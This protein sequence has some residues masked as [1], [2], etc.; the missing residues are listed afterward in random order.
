LGKTKVIYYNIFF[1]LI[2][3]CSSG[4]LNPNSSIQD[5]EGNTL[6]R[7]SDMPFVKK[8]KLNIEDRLI[9]ENI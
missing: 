4:N 5:A 3:G 6:T 1:T 7:I 8:T 2:N 9:L